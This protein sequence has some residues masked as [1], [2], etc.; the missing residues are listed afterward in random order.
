MHFADVVTQKK[1]ALDPRQALPRVIDG[2]PQVSIF[3]FTLPHAIDAFN[4]PQSIFSQQREACV[5]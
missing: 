5:L 3:S 4:S 1:A 2:N